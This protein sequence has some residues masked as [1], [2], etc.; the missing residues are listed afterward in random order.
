MGNDTLVGGAGNDTLLGGQGAD[1]YN[2]SGDFGNDTLVDSDGAYA[3]NAAMS[4]AHLRH[5]SFTSQLV[6]T[7]TK[8][9]AINRIDT[10]AKGIFTYQPCTFKRVGRPGLNDMCCLSRYL[11]AGCTVTRQAAR[12][13][14]VR[15]L[16]VRVLNQAQP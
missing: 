14:Q 3:P 4:K 2:F 11:G 9:I 1:T 13:E 12:C 5:Y 15:Q 7:T 10:A 16:S 6:T 8:L